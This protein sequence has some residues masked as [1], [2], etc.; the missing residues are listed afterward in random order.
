MK[1]V[2]LNIATVLV[3]LV[4]CGTGGLG[5]G[6][7]PGIQNRLTAAGDDATE[8]DSASPSGA[9]GTI[10]G[11]FA[12]QPPDAPTKSPLPRPTPHEGFDYLN[13]TLTIASQTRTSRASNSG[14]APFGQSEQYPNGDTKCPGEAPVA[15]LHIHGSADNDVPTASGRFAAQYWA[16]VNGCGTTKAPMASYSN[17]SSN[18]GCP[19]GK[20]VVYC[21]VAGMAHTIWDQSSQVAWSFFKSL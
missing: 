19:V 12:L 21:E 7:D 2:C 17:Y 16:N 3:A 4:G 14:G 15:A 20:G 13:R 9:P 6:D 1:R 5:E 11:P 18:A 10:S 8:S